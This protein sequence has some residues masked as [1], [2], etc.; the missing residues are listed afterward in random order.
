MRFT[1][2]VG[3]G[4][5]TRAVHK[6]DIVLFHLTH[7]ALELL[8][9]DAKTC[10]VG[11]DR[12]LHLAHAECDNIAA[13]GGGTGCNGRVFYQLSE[14]GKVACAVCCLGEEVHRL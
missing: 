7:D 10:A 6:D 9:P 12:T 3:N 8:A 4:S 5:Q 13:L 11:M 2:Q 14:N 1:G